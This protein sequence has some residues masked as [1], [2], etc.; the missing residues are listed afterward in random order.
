M[1]M[2][3][4]TPKVINKTRERRKAERE[5]IIEE[6]KAMMPAPTDVPKPVTTEDGKK[7]T[8]Q[9]EDFLDCLIDPESGGDIRTA[10]VM[11]G[12]GPSARMSTIT[13][14]LENEI[15][16]RTALWLQV[17]SAYAAQ[18]IFHVMNDPS[19]PGNG[20]LLKAATEVLDRAGV[21][22]KYEHES[23][24]AKPSVAIILPPKDND[25]I[26]VENSDEE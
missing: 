4:E 26:V 5:K 9:Q 21:G 25:V 19:R 17:Q 24:H 15:A 7:L 1:N 10:A 13:R 2:D 20:L 22:K 23:T 14:G 11:A 6:S 12:Y 3:E 16:K 8:K 18:K